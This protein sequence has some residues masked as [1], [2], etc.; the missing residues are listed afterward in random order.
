ME[1]GEVLDTRV[2]TVKNEVMRQICCYSDY[3]WDVEGWEE[4]GWYVDT[5]DGYNRDK[6]LLRKDGVLAYK[7]FE[8]TDNP[9]KKKLR[10][11]FVT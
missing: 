5:N 11:I 3:G 1:E 2:L 8:F 10:Q 6:L 7:E 9:K 4:L